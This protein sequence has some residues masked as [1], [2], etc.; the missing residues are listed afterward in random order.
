MHAEITGHHSSGI[1]AKTSKT[2]H[3]RSKKPKSENGWDCNRA[4]EQV[5]IKFSPYC[6]PEAGA[7]A[8]L[9]MMLQEIAGCIREIPFSGGRGTGFGCIAEI[10]MLCP[11]PI[12]SL[13]KF[14]ET[15]KV[16]RKVAE[17]AKEGRQCPI[18]PGRERD[19][20]EFMR[21][22]RNFTSANGLQEIKKK[23]ILPM[24]NGSGGCPVE[25][26]AWKDIER[27]SEYKL[28]TSWNF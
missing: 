19:A 3:F 9:R 16:I 25:F 26:L 10:C 27:I 12:S 5:F 20:E 8:N 2:R 4:V 18:A 1:R 7:T 15:Y 11:S 14:R 22:L 13:D 28:G 17:D 23:A 6:R 24:G 21:K